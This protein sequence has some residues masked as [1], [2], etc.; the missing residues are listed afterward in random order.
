MPE[1]DLD[2][3]LMKP[4][5]KFL[6]NAL[7]FTACERGRTARQIVPLSGCFFTGKNETRT[8][9]AYGSDASRRELLPDQGMIVTCGAVA[10]GLLVNVPFFV[11]VTISL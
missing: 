9:W 5:M 4:I 2:V 3:A 10:A 1:S 7:A 6:R 8:R 11:T